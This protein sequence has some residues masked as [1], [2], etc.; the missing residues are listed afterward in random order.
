M[1]SALEINMYSFL[2]LLIEVNEKFF[3]T[4]FESCVWLSYLDLYSVE[5]AV[6][7]WIH[8]RLS[9]YHCSLEVIV[10]N[11]GKRNNLIAIPLSCPF[12]WSFFCWFWCFSFSV[13]GNLQEKTRKNNRYMEWKMTI[14]VLFV[15]FS[16]GSVQVQCGDRCSDVC[17]DQPPLCVRRVDR[18]RPWQVSP[19][20]SQWKRVQNKAIKM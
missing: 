10:F 7:R 4:V 11:M 6:I 17:H 13:Y 3:K 8:R 2:F 14:L 9:T 20:L 16:P 12:S 1:R 19:A 5:C 15:V 18:E